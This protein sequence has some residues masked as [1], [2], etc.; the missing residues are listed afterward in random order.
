MSNISD[1]QLNQV[2]DD[3]GFD[4]HQRDAL[5]AFADQWRFDEVPWIDFEDS[6]IGEVEG[7]SE[8]AAIGNFVHDIHQDN[9]TL[10]GIPTDILYNIDWEGVGRDARWGGDYHA[11]RAPQWGMWFVFRNL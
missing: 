7:S 2:M 11:V 5:R 3:L 4:D 1:R 8:D 10:D 9:G 6:F